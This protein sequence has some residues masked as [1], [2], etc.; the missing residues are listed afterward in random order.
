MLSSNRARSDYMYF[1][2]YVVREKA[3][4]DNIAYEVYNKV[5]YW[6][7]IAFFNDIQNPF[8]TLHVGQELNIL[9]NE[10]IPILLKQVKQLA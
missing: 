7:I 5:E 9:K 8:E 6:W 10:Y 2:K 3:F 1:T 4:W